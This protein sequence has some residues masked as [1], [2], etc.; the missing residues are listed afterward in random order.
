MPTGLQPGS[1]RPIH[2]PVQSAAFCAGKIVNLD[3]EITELDVIGYDAPE[4]GS[5]T[6]I[7][8]AGLVTLL[9][10]LRSR[11]HSLKILRIR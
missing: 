11:S 8:V 4:P 6:F 1:A 10:R 2:P 7:S 3:Q 5:G 9:C